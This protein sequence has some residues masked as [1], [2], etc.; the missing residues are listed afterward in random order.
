[1]AEATRRP[2]EEFPTGTVLPMATRV[3]TREEIISF[4]QE[5]DPQPMHL[6]AAAAEKTMLGGLSASGWHVCS[7]MMRM[8]C[9]SFL[10]SSTSQGSPGVDTVRWQ[11]P[12]RPGDELTGETRVLDAR[13]SQSRPTIG[14]LKMRT[15]LANQRQEPVLVSEYT[16]MMLTRS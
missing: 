10:N 9:D 12:V 5:Y 7:I 4:A 6:D 15:T 2:F 1:M 16:V 8:M 14:I 11:Q 3:V 13:R